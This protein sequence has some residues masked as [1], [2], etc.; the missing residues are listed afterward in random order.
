MAQVI[1]CF[2][3]VRSENVFG[4]FF[5]MMYILRHK[6]KSFVQLRGVDLSAVT[7][8]Q[9]QFNGAKSEKNSF[10]THSDP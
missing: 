3:S 4:M 10:S 9:Q 1:K 2:S 8:L 5:D 7:K 6:M